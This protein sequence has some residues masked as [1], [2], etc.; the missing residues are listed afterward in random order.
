MNLKPSEWSFAAKLSFVITLFAVV[1]V[2][3]GL[4]SARI[5]AQ[6]QIGGPYYTEIVLGKDLVADILPPPAYIIEAYLLC[7]EAA[8]TSSADERAKALARLTQ[9]EKEYHD[10]RQV[11]RDALP[12]SRMKTALV[13]DSAQPAEAFFK[14]LHEQFVPAL[15][16]AD[17]DK[18]R[19]LAS[20]EMHEAYARHRQFID[21]VVTLANQ[22]GSDHEAE[23]AS[24]VRHGRIWETA[25]GVSGLLIGLLLGVGIV[26][27]LGRSLRAL[28]KHLAGEAA[29]MATEAAQVSTSSQTSA[30]GA[31]E[32]AASLQETSASLEE[33][34]SMTKRNAENSGRA[35]ALSTQTRAAADSGSTEMEVMKQAMDAITLSASNIA[36]IVKSID[37]IAFQTNILALNAAVEAARAGEAG[38][39]FAVVAEEVR[40]LAQRSAQAAKETAERI[41]DSVRK[42]EHGVQISGQVAQ[43]FAVIGEKARQVD[44]LIAE[45]ATASHEQTH[46]IEQVNTA[47]SR[48]DKITQSNAAAAAESAAA[49]DA[50]TA[51]A[52]ELTAEIGQ[53]LAMV[54][55]KAADEPH[56]RPGSPQP[57][58]QPNRDRGQ[59]F[60]PA[61]VNATP[62]DKPAAVQPPARR[63]ALATPSPR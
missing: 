47:V 27:G 53:L 11:W 19:R 49:A 20:G 43:H 50:L 63:D 28:G 4:Y 9:A 56:R 44:T 37:E 32:Q 17:Y 39:G 18:A 16:A 26:R 5:R 7:Y 14:I 62:P 15:V 59:N 10:R 30:E 6:V 24:V 54:D 46:G 61:S 38:A 40:A 36:K 34:S 42:S 8:N 52:V 2:A 21:E 45:I 23:A 57:A 33:I 3:F 29:Q 60:H 55:G 35:K 1:L 13:T 48:M 25:I 51:Q 58:G 22:F 12:D 41:E 31:S